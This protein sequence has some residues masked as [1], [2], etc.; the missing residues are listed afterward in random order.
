[1]IREHNEQ[2]DGKSCFSNFLCSEEIL[3]FPTV[4]WEY[5]PFLGGP[6]IVQERT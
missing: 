1:M 3:G 6:L 2:D 5:I 4:V